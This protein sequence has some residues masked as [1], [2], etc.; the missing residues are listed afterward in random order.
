M[1]EEEVDSPVRDIETNGREGNG[2]FEDGDTAD[3]CVYYC[4]GSR[5]EAG[6]VAGR[7][8]RGGGV[9]VNENHDGGGGGGGGGVVAERVAGG[10]LESDVSGFRRIT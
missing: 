6:G 3:A 8:G 7:G 5:G 1:P 9:A 4:G 10:C 2:G